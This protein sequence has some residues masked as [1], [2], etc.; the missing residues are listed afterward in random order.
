MILGN[1]VEWALHCMSVLGRMPDGVLVSAKL[2]A[3]FHGVPK[4]YLSKAMQALAGAGLVNTTSGP[5]G[6]YSLSRIPSKI[7]MLDIVEA[8]EG[9]KITFNCQEIRGNIPCK[10]KP[11][12]PTSVC[13]IASVMY[14]ADNAWRD[15]LRKQKLSDM[16][17]AVD[18]VVPEEALKYSNNWLLEKI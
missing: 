8:V 10:G 16:I 3:E 2:L 6:G 17:N 13:T 12:K 15:V 14:K 18:E 1:Q 7:T 9:K 5:K 11:G 4:E